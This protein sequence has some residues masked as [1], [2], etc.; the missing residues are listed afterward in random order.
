MGF[1]AKTPRFG[2]GQNALIDLRWRLS[3]ILGRSLRSRLMAASGR[4][5]PAHATPVSRSVRF[6]PKAT[7]SHLRKD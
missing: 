7:I 1:V 2:D 3:A 6:A 5:L 4:S